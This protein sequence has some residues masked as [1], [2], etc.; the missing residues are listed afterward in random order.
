[1]SPT[2]KKRVSLESP[3][4]HD[5]LTNLSCK[6]CMKTKIEYMMNQARIKNLFS[7]SLKCLMMEDA[8]Q[9]EH[10]AQIQDKFDK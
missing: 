2:R 1:M 5:D 4:K 10:I 9:K 6:E 7:L 3:S 8:A